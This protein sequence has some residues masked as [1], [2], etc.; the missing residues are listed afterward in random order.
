VIKNFFIRII[1]FVIIVSYIYS[2]LTIKAQ[3]N[4]GLA[5]SLTME[6]YPENPAPHSIVTIT[7]ITYAFDIDRAEISW[8]VD[9]KIVKTGYGIKKHQV[10][11]DKEG[12]S[13]FVEAKVIAAEGGVYYTAITLTP[14]SVDL[15]WESTDSYVPPFY[16]GKALPGEGG[17]V[18]IIAIPT[19][20]DKKNKIPASDMDYKW[21]VEDEAAQNYSGYGKQIFPMKLDILENKSSVKVVVT[22]RNGITS[23]ENFTDISPNK[24]QIIF[25]E[26][27][28]LLGV[29]YNKR[30]S[31]YFKLENETLGITAEPYFYSYKTN[32]SS[33]AFDWAINVYL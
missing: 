3:I 27:D 17:I 29:K 33:L 4:P 16:K 12:I 6:I 14:Q 28:N 21:F 24:G 9:G 2:P 11:L 18:N 23:A 20:Y 5:Q 1:S 10:K 31:N 30:L 8:A 13:K 22:P 19:I 15:I 7:L 26:K 32:F 25:Y